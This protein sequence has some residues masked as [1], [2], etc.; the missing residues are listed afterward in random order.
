[1][2]ASVF[3]GLALSLTASLAWSGLDAARKRLAN[4]LDP[5]ALVALITLA[6]APV[7]FVLASLD[8]AWVWDQRYWLPALASLILNGTANVLFMWSIRLSPLS[9]TV[10]YLS[11][12]PVFSTILANL[13]LGE[14][15]E[16]IQKIG[17]VSI[18][19][20][21]LVLAP[22][23]LPKNTQQRLRWGRGSLMMCMVALLWSCTAVFDK[24]ALQHASVG[25]HAFI[26]S[27]GMGL[28]VLLI[29]AGQQRIQELSRLWTYKWLC[30]ASFILAIIALIFQ[31]MAIKVVLIGFYETIKRALGMFMAIVLGRLLFKEPITWG[32]IV[33]V[34]LL[35]LGT[36]LL[37]MYS[38]ISNGMLERR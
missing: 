10:P 22:S 21:A 27:C 1:M 13:I 7:F 32:K 17:L 23:N 24:L 2:P 3:S 20:G 33:A 35:A 14:S 6:T 4:E 8:G 30:L 9:L 16:F 31:L 12:T 18:L 34:I 26:Q 19:L 11:L 5:F 28:I 37:L 29:L 15:F 36:G 25:A 38:P